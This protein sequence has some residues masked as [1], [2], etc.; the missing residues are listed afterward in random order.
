MQSLVKI[1]DVGQAL[2]RELVPFALSLVI[3]QIFFKW[4]N[5]GLE[6]LGFFAI[7]WILGLAYSR[8]LEALA[9]DCPLSS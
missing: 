7:W 8:L 6:L 3:A 4:G 9:R 2:R 1:V 5:F